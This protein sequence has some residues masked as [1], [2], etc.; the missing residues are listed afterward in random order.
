MARSRRLLAFEG[1]EVLSDAVELLA[2][3]FAGFS[4]HV[5]AAAADAQVCFIDRFEGF[6]DDVPHV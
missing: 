4:Q 1:A 2:K 6:F 3:V 5:D